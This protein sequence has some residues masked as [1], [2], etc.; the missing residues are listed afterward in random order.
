M[1]PDGKKIAAVV[2]GEIFILSTEGGYA[3]NVTRTPWRERQPVWDTDSLKIY[4]ISDKNANPDLYKVSALGGEKPERLTRSEE[5]ELKPEVSPDGKWLAYFRGTRQLRLLELESKKDT[6]LL[7]DDLYGLRAAP[8]AW[9]P[10]SRFI[11]VEISRNANTDLFAVDILS[12]EKQLLTN[13]AYDEG[14]PFWT[15]DGRSLLF[16]SNRFGHSFPE[17]S[18]K[19]DL[20]QLH[21]E[22]QK[23]EFEEDDFEKLFRPEEDAADK[24]DTKKKDVPHVELTLKDIDRQTQPVTDTLGDDREFILNPKDGTTVYF[25]STTDGPAH[26][27][28][29]SL[30]KKKRGKY[31]PF[32][33]AVFSPRQLQTDSKG[34]SLYYLSRGAI[35]RIDLGSNRSSPISFSTRIEVD[36]TARISWLS[37]ISTTTCSARTRN[38]TRPSKPSSISSNN[39]GQAS[40]FQKSFF[41]ASGPGQNLC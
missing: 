31:E 26:L 27:W 4:Y 39:W 9:S 36:K 14:G 40:F 1:S 34:T 35:G 38:S 20:Y 22:P 11:A 37:T 5:D 33:P 16:T 3:R 10:D 30:D 28:T 15:P 17:F 13:T 21:L 25:V 41:A 24:N 23:P 8:P 18:G 19:W 32:V 12:K 29:T 7:E 6:L 2:R